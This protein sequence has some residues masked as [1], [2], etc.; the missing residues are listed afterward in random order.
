MKQ[1][2]SLTMIFVLCSLALSPL[3]LALLVTCNSE[4][5]E[6]AFASKEPIVLVPRMHPSDP[7]AERF[8]HKSKEVMA[9]D[10]RRLSD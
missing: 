2:L 4:R 7:W 10:G 5:F 8:R 9:P 3:L 1:P 6:K